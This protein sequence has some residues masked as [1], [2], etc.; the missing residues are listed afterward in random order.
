MQRADVS[1]FDETRVQRLVDEGKGRDKAEVLD[2]LRKAESAHGLTPAEAA[3]LL[4]TEEPAIWEAIF[5]TAKKVKERIYGSRIVLFAPLYLSNYCVN[6]CTY[7]GY[8]QGS[9]ICR[10]KLTQEEIA[11]EVEALEDL[12]HKRLAIEVGEDPVN[13][14]LDY[15][16]ESIRT[17]YKIRNGMGTIRRVNVNIAAT[18]E[19]DYRKLKDVGIGTYILFQETYHRATYERLHP[20][21]P[22]HDF[23][24]HL[25]AFDRAMAGGI[26][27]V[28]S[29][30]LFGL[31]DYR[32]EVV[33]LL[34]HAAHLEQ[35]FGVG[36]HTVS[37]PRL[38]PAEGVNPENFPYLISD[39][40]IKQIV[41]VFRLA[42]PY[43]GIILSTRETPES[44]REVINVGVSQISAGSCTGVG[45]Y[46]EGL[47]EKRENT[48]QFEVGDH[49]SPNEVLT[50]LCRDGYIPSFCTACYRQGR[51]G[52]RFMALAK[53]GEIGKVCA[54]NAILTFQE[55]LM[56]Y[57]KGETR[58]EG[59]QR[60]LESVKGLPEEIRADVAWRLDRIRRGERDLYY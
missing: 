32:F 18:T 26:D 24:W 50:E 56:D 9:G 31:Y 41:A 38:R 37:V 12:G 45:G 55:Y 16:L 20:T 34:E 35:V 40:E 11:A 27:D 3:I 58:T 46:S 13:C 29:G 21:G 48:A 42:M 4:Q 5:E 28:G 1:W 57:A 8:H 2:I 25:S 49:R 43:T 59:E 7:C 53:S 33:A 60:I 19:E 47:K 36:P 39:Q 51:T 10:R 54:P 22:K 15:V 44:R 6:G 23:A 30:I 17:I 52:D 14:P